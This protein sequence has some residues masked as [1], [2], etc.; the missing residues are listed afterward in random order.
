MWEDFKQNYG[1]SGYIYQ[2]VGTQGKPEADKPANF[3][4][5]LIDLAA[6]SEDEIRKISGAVQELLGISRSPD[7]SGKAI[8]ALKSGGVTVIAPL[9]D[10]LVRSDRLLGRQVTDLIQQYFPPEKL[11]AIVGSTVAQRMRAEAMQATEQGRLPMDPMQRFTQALGTRFDVIVDTAPIL[12]SER[13]R[14][15]QSLTEVYGI[16]AQAGMVQVLP[17]LLKSIY[18]V[19][20]FPNKQQ[21]IQAIEQGGAQQFA[22]AQTPSGGT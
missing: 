16:S 17:L 19:S 15:L 21:V 13:E 1:K 7:Q 8:N 3:P 5:A 20:N 14:Q 12:G 4:T 18:E 10:S 9:F 22:P 6:L 11:A 2:Y